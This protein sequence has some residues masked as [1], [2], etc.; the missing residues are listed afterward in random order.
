MS[1]KYYWYVE[2]TVSLA[3]MANQKLPSLLQHTPQCITPNLLWCVENPKFLTR[4][5]IR[6]LFLIAQ[7]TLRN[8]Q[9]VVGVK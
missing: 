8:L 9:Y 1:Q 6:E 2:N 5:A 4:L 7:R 3:F